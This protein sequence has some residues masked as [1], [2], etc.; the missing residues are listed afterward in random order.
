MPVTKSLDP[1][2]DQMAIEAVSQWRF[3]PGQK[4]GAPVPVMASVEVNFRIADRPNR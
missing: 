3:R 2:L 1:G 4:G